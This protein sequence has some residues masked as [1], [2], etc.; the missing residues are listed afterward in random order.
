MKNIL[1]SLTA[2]LVGSVVVAS[3]AFA[4]FPNPDGSIPQQETWQ[5]PQPAE[6]VS[7]LFASA[8]DGATVKLKLTID[9]QGK[10]SDIDVVF[11]HD[12]QLKRNLV[13]AIEQW[14]F[15]PARKNG[16]AVKVRVV[17][18]IELKTDPNA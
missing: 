16:E 1:K 14:T 9:E 18:P 15:E 6:I 17:M 13:E 10:P 11:P 7:P 8:H 12:P 2:V 3:A 5:P 4:A